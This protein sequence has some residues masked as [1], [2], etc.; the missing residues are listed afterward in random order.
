MRVDQ[1]VAGQSCRGRETGLVGETQQCPGPGQTQLDWAGQT[2]PRLH[3]LLPGGHT[4]Q[5]GGVTQDKEQIYNLL[6]TS[7][8]HEL[9]MEGYKKKKVLNFR[10]RGIRGSASSEDQICLKILS[11]KCSNLKWCSVTKLFYLRF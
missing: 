4:E 2:D 5:S 3:L 11:S 1:S 10:V 8:R 6:I 7:S 9:V